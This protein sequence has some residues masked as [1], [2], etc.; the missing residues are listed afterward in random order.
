MLLLTLL[1]CT[2]AEP[3]EVAWPTAGC[4][5]EEP[6]WDR[7]TELSSERFRLL[8]P[9]DVVLFAGL[10]LPSAPG[11]YPALMLVPPGFETGLKELD[12][13]VT[14][15]LAGA[16]VAV[17]AFDPRGRGSSD[18]E[19][20]MN[21]PLQQDDLAAALSWLAGQPQVDPD[22]VYLRSRSYGAAMAA[23]ALDRN[24]EIDPAG[25]M[26]IESPS[27][28]PDDLERVQGDNPGWEDAPDY[29]DA[30]WWGARSPDQHIHANR[31]HYLRIQGAVDHAL[32]DYLG[33]AAILLD[34]STGAR[35]VSLNGQP[36]DGRAW[37]EDS[38]RELALS[39]TPAWDEERVIELLMALLQTE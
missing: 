3:T 39:G 20:D 9:D 2:D 14:R 24:P 21:G 1:A 8:R 11:C 23:G 28:M 10:E 31:G 12:T 27:T 34:A 33:A 19:E 36:G 15:R 4:E 16:G 35:S 22:R 18:G 26:D 13:G 32:G 25:L 7:H 5:A 6:A 30:E 17:M 37:T 38:V 29:S